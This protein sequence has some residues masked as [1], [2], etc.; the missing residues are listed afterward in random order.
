PR[1][2]PDRGRC[3]FVERR[4]CRGHRIVCVASFF[5]AP[6]YWTRR[7]EDTKNARRTHCLE[8]FIVS[9]PRGRRSVGV[10]RPPRKELTSSR[11][12][13]MQQTSHISLSR[14]AAN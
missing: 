7:H 9:W 12:D 1:A 14:V 8:A 10:D 3:G 6:F 4:G 13:Q 11:A 2:N 5:I